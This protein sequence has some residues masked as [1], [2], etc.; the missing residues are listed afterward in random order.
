MVQKGQR[1]GD[2]GKEGGEAWE[3]S[4]G[5][6]TRKETTAGRGK[7]HMVRFTT[8]AVGTVA[9]RTQR[10]GNHDEVWAGVEKEVGDAVERKWLWDWV[11]GQ[12]RKPW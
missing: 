7:S 1:C 4:T 12:G 9:H 3:E 2:G 5:C 8:S 6:D 11:P 10:E